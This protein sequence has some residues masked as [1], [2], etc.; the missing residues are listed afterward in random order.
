M[1]S[2]RLNLVRSEDKADIGFFRRLFS[3]IEGLLNGQSRNSGTLTLSAGATSTDVDDA[4]FQSGQRVVLFPTSAHA[5]AGAAST[6][7]SAKTT[8][9]F[10]VTHPNTADVDKTFDYIFIG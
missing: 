9:Q 7:V 3:Q 4:R 10:T 5:A 6:Y 8:G 2:T 1:S